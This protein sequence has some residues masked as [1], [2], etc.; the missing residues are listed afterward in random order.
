[1]VTG[2]TASNQS[3]L[4]NATDRT[5]G[6]KVD[7][8]I[9]ALRKQLEG[10]II[11]QRNINDKHDQTIARLETSQTANMTELT[12]MLNTGLRDGIRAATTQ[13]TETMTTVLTNFT[14]NANNNTKRQCE[15]STSNHSDSNDKRRRT[16]RQA[17]NNPISASPSESTADGMTGYEM[18]EAD[19]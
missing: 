1:M 11:D 17:N 12:N 16:L 5:T 13:L 8:E 10:F 9:E 18:E 7:T 3:T 19:T 2:D 15:P 4:T 6:N 14:N